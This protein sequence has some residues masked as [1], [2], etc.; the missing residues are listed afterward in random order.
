MAL[1]EYVCHDCH[2]K[3]DAFRSMSQADVPINC[4]K[5]DSL[6]TERALSQFAM[7]GAAKGPAQV[8]D[9]DTRQS[10]MGGGGCCGGGVCGCGG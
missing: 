7:V 9:A 4:Q 1:Y 2:T 6:N 8:T 5:C 10:Y 3:F